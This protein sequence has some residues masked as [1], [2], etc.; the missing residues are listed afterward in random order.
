MPQR[1]IETI[2]SALD[3]GRLFI[4]VKGAKRPW[5]ARRNGATKVWK[6]RPNDFRIPIKYGFKGYG[7]ITHQNLDSEEIVIE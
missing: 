6:T 7:A 5:R 2:E 1:T 4:R 3:A